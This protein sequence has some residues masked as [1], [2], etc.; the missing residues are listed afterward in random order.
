M[1]F[2]D[3]REQADRGLC[4]ARNRVDLAEVVHTGLDDR[5]LML[6]CKPQQHLGRTYGVVVVGLGAQRGKAPGEHAGDHLLG[7]GLSGAAGDLHHRDGKLPPVPGRQVLQRQKGILHLYVY[8]AGNGVCH[9]AHGQAAQGAIMQGG[10]QI[11]V[12]VELLTHQRYEQFALAYPAAVGGDAGKNAPALEQRA[13]YGIADLLYGTGPHT[14]SAF[15]SS[16]ESM[17]IFSHR[18]A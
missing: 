13:V 5:R 6:G 12:A 11:V 1:C 17:T 14:F 8:L 2:A 18:S 9:V 16:K 4:N 15:L 7:G 10:G 3:V